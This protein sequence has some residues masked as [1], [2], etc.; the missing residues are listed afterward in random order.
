MQPRLGLLRFYTDA[1]RRAVGGSGLGW[2]HPVAPSVPWSCNALIGHGAQAGFSTL[3]LMDRPK[4]VGEVLYDSFP[5]I[6]S[7]Y[8]LLPSARR[9]LLLI[10]GPSEHVDN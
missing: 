7:D 5:F 4:F 8:L 6:A 9:L 1:V 10:P 2:T 3:S